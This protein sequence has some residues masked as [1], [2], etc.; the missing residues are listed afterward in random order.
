MIDE[1]PVRFFRPPYVGH[2]GWVGVRID[3]RP[4]WK[5]VAGVMRDAHDF[6]ISPPSRRR[7]LR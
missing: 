6:V 1:D 5:V 4:D 2:K 7:S 3:G